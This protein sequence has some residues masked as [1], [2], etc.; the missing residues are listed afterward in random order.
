MA[1]YKLYYFNGKGRA[2]TIRM[3]FALKGVAY[4]DIRI[5]NEKWLE[6]KPETPFGSLPVLEEN[7]K[8]LAGSTIIARYLGEKYGLAGNNSWENAEISNSVDFMDD[9]TKAM[10]AMQFEKD[11]AKKA[12]LKEAFQK[13]NLPKYLSRLEKLVGEEGY[14]CLF[15]T[16]ADLYLY[17]QLDTLVGHGISLDPYPGLRTLQRNIEAIPAI[18]KWLNERPQTSF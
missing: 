18:A 16:W 11:E 8:M 10:V 15:L 14:I 5:P 4:E 2:E 1:S 3:I 9:F 13:E 6:F 7:G 17:C 12:E